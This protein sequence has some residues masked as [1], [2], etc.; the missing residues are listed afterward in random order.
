MAWFQAHHG[1]P[2]T[3]QVDGATAGALRH[4]SDAAL[5][6]TFR[7]ADDLGPEELATLIPPKGYPA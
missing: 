2:A 6:R 4:A 7:T 5:L 3:G 1:L